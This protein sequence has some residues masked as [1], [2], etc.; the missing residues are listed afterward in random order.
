VGAIEPTTLEEALALLQADQWKLAMEDEMHSLEQNETW[1]LTKLPAGRQPIQNR[2]VFKLKL[3]GAVRRYKAR[4]VA[5]GFTQRTGVDFEE[6]LS[7][8]VK[9]DSL[10]AVL[11][12][13]AERD[14]NMLQL[15]VKTAFLNGD[16]N[17]ELYMTQPTG[18]IVSGREGE[19]CKLN[20]KWSQY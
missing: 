6:I 7:P 18:F 1:T 3:D 11:A 10:R 5:K 20:R 9:H 12:M 8:V 14:H 19:V 16:L 13:A 2:W 17:E 4:L 15:D